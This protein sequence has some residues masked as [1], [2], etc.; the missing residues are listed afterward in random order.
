MIVSVLAYLL[1]LTIPTSALA[2]LYARWE[3]R[4]RGR[5]T[6]V[7]LFLLCAMLF[8]PNL[9]LHYAMDYT[10]PSTLGDYIGV[11]VGAFGLALCVISIALFRSISKMLCLDT[12]EL[13]LS[14]PYRWSRNPQYVGWLLFLLGFALNDWSLW[15]LAALAVVATSLHLLVLVEEEHLRRVFGE[16]YVEFC[17]KVPRYFGLHSRA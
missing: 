2:L 17:R 4:K 10:I 3:Y 13:T 15:C 5:L 1:A 7:G 16:R 6:F 11:V 12:G 14:G 9:V 8:V